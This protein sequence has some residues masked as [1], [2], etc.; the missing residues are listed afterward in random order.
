MIRNLLSLVMIVSLGACAGASPPAPP[1][2][3]DLSVSV[4]ADDTVNPDQ[5]GRPSPLAIRVYFLTGTEAI[6]DA[7]LLALWQ[8]EAATLAGTL[9]ERRDFL[10]APGSTAAAQL[11]LPERVTSIAV[12]AAY[13]NFRDA[14][15]RVTLPVDAGA[16]APERKLTLTITASSQTVTA[17]LHPA[18]TAG[19]EDS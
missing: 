15:W 9:V 12:A 16:G 11:A 17:D 8:A 2:P 7:D 4:I 13:R 5:E 3:V 6:A 18:S 10:L 19:A 14:T 1:V